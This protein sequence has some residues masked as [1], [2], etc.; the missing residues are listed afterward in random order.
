MASANPLI[1]IFLSTAEMKTSCMCLTLYSLPSSTCRL[2]SVPLSL[3]SLILI[4]PPNL[5]QQFLSS[6]SR[7]L[8]FLVFTSCLLSGMPCSTQS[9]Q[10][11]VESP[12]F[13]ARENVD[14]TPRAETQCC[15]KTKRR[16]TGV[17]SR[18]VWLTLPG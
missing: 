13:S 2:Y 14:S 15:W 10:R 5:P 18:K 7:R 11:W 12:S 1:F 17:E 3:L 6:L 8:L 4:N 9:A 16:A